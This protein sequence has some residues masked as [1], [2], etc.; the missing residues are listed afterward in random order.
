MIKIQ[1]LLMLLLCLPYLQSSA[2][3][4]ERLQRVEPAFWWTGMKNSELQLMVYGKNIAELEPSFQYPGVHLERITKVENPNYLFLT[5]K[6]DQSAAPG[7]FEL[8][9]KKSGKITAQYSYQLLEREPNSFLR[10]GFSTSDAIYLITPDRFVNGNPANDN[11]A[12]M[13]EKVDRK[14][15][16]G[17]H[18][19]DLQGVINSLD[20]IRDLGFTALWINP[21]LENNQPTYSY[22][23]Y[24][25]TD[26]Y[27]VDPRFGTNKDYKQLSSL[28]KQKGMKLIM[29]MVVNHCGSEHWWMKDL[30]SSDWLNFPDSFVLT[31]HKRTSIQDVYAAR[32]DYTQMVDGWFAKTMPDLN[33]R[34]P[35]VATYLIQNSIWWVEYAGLGGIRMDTYP[36]SDTRFLTDWSRSIMEEYPNFNIVGEEWSENPA[37]VSFWQKN[38]KNYNGYVS[39]LPTLMDFPIQAAVVQGLKEKESWNTGFIKMYEMLAND[40]LYPNPS[41]LVVFPDNHDIMRFYELLNRDLELYKL[42]IT[43]YL[44][45]RGIPQ[46]FYGTEILLSGGQEEKHGT[47]RTDFPGGWEGDSVN[48]FTNRGL[49]LQQIEAKNFVRRLLNWRKNATVIHEGKLMHYVPQNGVYVLFRYNDSK[50]VM[51]ILNKND[52]EQTIPLNRFSEMLAGVKAGFDVLND[53]QIILGNSLVIPAKS[54]LVIEIK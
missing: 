13:K 5:L 32:A 36:Y 24:S 23:G 16:D 14:N 25:I 51:V 8:Y 52:Q 33:Q 45:I 7:S 15:Y 37:I 2:S 1:S 34:N 18:G 3:S 48:A 31:T 42:G 11:V 38:K 49:S 10:H 27:K 44:T 35:L 22:H 39:Y 46:L 50:K 17:R 41:Q 12:G 20:Y 26:F 4:N 19:G 29:D 30:P 40:F 53:R 6:I 9:F 28:A 43:Y 21:A 54:P 47:Y